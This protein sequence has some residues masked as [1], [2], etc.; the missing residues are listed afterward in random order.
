MD[1]I[2]S[3]DDVRLFDLYERALMELASGHASSGT[4][5]KEADTCLGDSSLAI[6]R[7][8]AIIN[9]AC[10]KGLDHARLI[11]KAYS[12]DVV[13]LIEAMRVKAME[14]RLGGDA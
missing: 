14:L 1:Q 13:T 7:R 5:S 11:Q 12:F 9:A 8:N 3:D 10:S 2:P 6:M 4:Y